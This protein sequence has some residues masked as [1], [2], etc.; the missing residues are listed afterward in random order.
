MCDLRLRLQFNKLPCLA[1]DYKFGHKVIKNFCYDEI[2]SPF[3]LIFSQQF[4]A[5]LS[6]DNCKIRDF[7]KK[8]DFMREE[9]A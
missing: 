4:V 1:R 8:T 5:I 3:P 9:L 7:P 6:T 2:F